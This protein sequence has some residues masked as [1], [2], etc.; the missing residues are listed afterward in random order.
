MK[1]IKGLVHG[2]AECKGCDWYCEDYLTLQRKA[3]EHANRTG[4]TVRVELGYVTEY[5]PIKEGG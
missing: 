5:R 4:H 3:R 1:A 2:I